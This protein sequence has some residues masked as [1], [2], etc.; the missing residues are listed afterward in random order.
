MTLIKYDQR[1]EVRILFLNILS[2]MVVLIFLNQDYKK[3][4]N[5][6]KLY[7]RKVINQRRCT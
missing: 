2:Y 1:D 5:N 3:L 4:I 7:T 6:A